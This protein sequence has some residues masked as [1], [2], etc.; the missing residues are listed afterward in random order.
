M[1]NKIIDVQEMLFKEMKRIDSD[2]F[3][4]NNKAQKQEEFQ[5]A[6]ALYNMSTGFIKTLNANL[7][8]MNLAKKNEGKYEDLMSKLGMLDEK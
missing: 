4:A 8:I 2:S 7:N 5:R 6:T 1:N 3:E